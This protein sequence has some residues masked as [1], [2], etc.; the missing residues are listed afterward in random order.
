MKLI[1][2]NILIFLTLAVLFYSCAANQADVNSDTKEPTSQNI[3]DLFGIS[4]DE[5][6][7]SQQSDEAEVLKLLGITKEESEVPLAAEETKPLVSD[8]KLSNEIEELEKLLSEKDSEIANLK[9]E[10]AIKDQ[11]ISQLELSKG[12]KS[13]IEYRTSDSYRDNYQDA[14]AN[15]QS[16][17]YKSA[18]SMFENLLARDYNNS[19]SD[20]CQYWIGESYYGLGNFN[21]AIVE[22]TKVFTFNKS[23]KADA[24]QLK[25]GL[26][27]WKL[28]DKSKARE[29]FERL[30]SDYPKSEFVEK[31]RYFLTKF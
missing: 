22:F 26:C 24:A 25:L 16:R 8:D 28:G 12:T 23:N 29:E 13:R 9:S 4:E 20:N 17:N 31:S 14:L 5:Q 10:L 6:S 21:Q 15:Y 30:I 1:L 3:D 11:K 2:K 27:Y 7:S 19:L 18:I